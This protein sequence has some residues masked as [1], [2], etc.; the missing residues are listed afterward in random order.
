MEW[1]AEHDGLTDK[2]AISLLQRIASASAAPVAMA[3][4]VPLVVRHLNYRTT[5]MIDA[6]QH[7]SFGSTQ[8]LACWSVTRGW[9]HRFLV[10]L[11][12]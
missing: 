7:T 1:L 3:N 6:N 8:W 11:S 9:G 12:I 4:L 5:S 10:V 2:M